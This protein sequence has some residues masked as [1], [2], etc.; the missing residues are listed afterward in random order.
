MENKRIQDDQIGSVALLTAAM[1]ASALG[2]TVVGAR[3]SRCSGA[4]RS[5]RL[6]I[7]EQ[8]AEINAQ[9]SKNERAKDASIVE[10]EGP[11]DGH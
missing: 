11:N 4:R 3:P 9:I 6:Q 1:L 10:E 2:I 8:Q 5:V 7:Q